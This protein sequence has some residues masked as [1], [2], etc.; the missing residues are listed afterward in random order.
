MVWPTENW[1]RGPYRDPRPDCGN[2]GSHR[3]KQAHRLFNQKNIL[4]Q[5]CR[6]CGELRYIRVTVEDGKVLSVDVTPSGTKTELSSD[7]KS[8]PDSGGDK[9]LTWINIVKLINIVNNC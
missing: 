4:F 9:G 6:I 7:D 2:G 1:G 8:P 5:T 3:F